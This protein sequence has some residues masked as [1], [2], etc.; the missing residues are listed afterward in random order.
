MDTD[1]G[2]VGDGEEILNGTDPLDPSDDVVVVDTGGL[3]LEGRT[4]EYLGGCGSSAKGS[5]FFGV[6]MG[7]LALGRRRQS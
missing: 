5:A 7:L 6:L 3:E 4:G 2:G 1:D